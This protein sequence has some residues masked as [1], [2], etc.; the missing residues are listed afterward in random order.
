MK[1]YNIVLA[2]NY[3]TKSK[4]QKT[5]YAPVGEIIIFPEGTKPDGSPKGESG[6]LKLH[7]TKEEYTVFPWK[8][9]DPDNSRS[10]NIP[11][12]DSVIHPQDNYDYSDMIDSIKSDALPPPDWET[13]G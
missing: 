13:Q 7:A 11:P 1:R 12:D 10:R 5:H 3:E 2:K 6:I 4:E 8:P 9:K